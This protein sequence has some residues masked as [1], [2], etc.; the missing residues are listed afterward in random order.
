MVV[1]SRNQISRSYFSNLPLIGTFSGSIA[2]VAAR[3]FYGMAFDFKS[4]ELY[5]FDTHHIFKIFNNVK[6]FEIKYCSLFFPFLPL[7]GSVSYS[8]VKD[9]KKEEGLRGLGN[10]LMTHIKR[11][12][13]KTVIFTVSLVALSFLVNGHLLFAAAPLLK[14]FDPSSHMILKITLSHC[15]QA[16]FDGAYEMDQSRTKRIMS[17]FALVIGITDAV[18]IYYTTL[19]FH[20]VAEIAAGIGIGL[21]IYSTGSVLASK[22]YFY[23]IVRDL[24][25]RTQK[26]AFKFRSV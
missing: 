3:L 26:L 19:Y 6:Q 23:E 11:I 24:P 16:S 2:G 17:L 22:E 8:A 12:P 13:A 1:E 21:L 10:H 15:F 5:K 9:W 4:P 25:N 20:T 14:G 7:I 18:L